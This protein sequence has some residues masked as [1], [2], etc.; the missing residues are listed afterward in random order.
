MKFD[1]VLNFLAIFS[2]C[3]L[4]IKYETRAFPKQKYKDASLNL[5]VSFFLVI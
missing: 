5:C 1:H 3:L 4:S 2:S